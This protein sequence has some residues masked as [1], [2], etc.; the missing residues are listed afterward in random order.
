MEN[1]WEPVYVRFRHLFEIIYLSIFYKILV[2]FLDLWNN[3]L[4]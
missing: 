3:Y 4:F 2:E 1:A